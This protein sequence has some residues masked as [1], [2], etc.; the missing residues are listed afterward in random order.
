MELFIRGFSLNDDTE[1]MVKLFK[2]LMNLFGIKTAEEGMFFRVRN[3][4]AASPL[5]VTTTL[6]IDNEPP[7]TQSAAA[8]ADEKPSGAKHR[9]FKLH[10][11]R[12]LRQR[13]QLT[14]APWGILHGVRPTKIA[15][16]WLAAG[17]EA[18]GIKG[19]LKQDYA[20]SE[21]KAELLTAIAVKQLP[22]MALSTEKT[23]SVYV[24]IPFCLSRC[25][26]CSFPS[27]VLPGE[28]KLTEF[29]RVFLKDLTAAKELID[30]YGFTVQSI[31]VGGGTPTS[32]P[33]PFFIAML[34]AVYRSFYHEG[35]AEFTLEAGR[36]DSMTEAK[37]LAMEQAK[38]TRVS[39]NPQTMKAATLQ[40]I[41]RRH[42]PEDIVAMYRRL[43]QTKIPHIN[44]DVILGL[45][46]ETVGDVRDTIAKVT[47]LNPDDI[48]LHA[49]AIK[50]GSR[51]KLLLEENEQTELPSDETVLEMAAFAH[52]YLRKS[53]YS[54][55][56]LYRQG[57]MRG[58]LENI[59]W[60]KPGAESLYNIEII[61]EAQTIIG[62]GGAATTKAVDHKNKRIRAAFHP[63]DLTTYLR[64]IDRYIDK[65][66]QVL[67]EVYGES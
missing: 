48:T 12:I 1:V 66:R 2:E 24:G 58:N 41:G 42:S 51:L 47:A 8:P 23:V 15:H 27:H 30:Q 45:P 50:K 35:L 32:L 21:A 3:E 60:A 34:E 44:M 31:Y 65:R 17:M 54:P 55:Y 22:L 10:L 59:G 40:R 62:L 49:L 61:E 64:D 28:Q 38:V 16:R 63:K 33:D 26:Y 20:C 56:Y 46:G 6:V 36:P 11:Y 57:Y 29:M 13:F 25:L 14:A 37:I 9:L 52:D 67:C 19:R 7:L 39:V 43:R 4:V 53:G 5:Q 18:E